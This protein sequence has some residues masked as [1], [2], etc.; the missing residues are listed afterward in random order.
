MKKSFLIIC[1][2]LFFVLSFPVFFTSNLSFAKADTETVYDPDICDYTFEGYTTDHWCTAPIAGSGI[3]CSTDEHDFYVDDRYYH[4]GC[5]QEGFGCNCDPETAYYIIE[6]EYGY[7][8]NSGL[9]NTA[10]SLLTFCGSENCTRGNYCNSSCSCCAGFICSSS[11]STIGYCYDPDLSLSGGET[12]YGNPECSSWKCV[13][14][15][16]AAKESGTGDEGGSGSGDEGVGGVG[17]TG[18]SGGIDN[19]I[20]ADFLKI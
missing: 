2:S 12:C 4:F 20:D 19:P 1:L 9:C 15:K 5:V 8:S 13:D 18:G 16:C 17:S 11:N 7:N 6:C 14:G 10:E 3:S